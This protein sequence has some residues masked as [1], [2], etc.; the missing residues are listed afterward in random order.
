MKKIIFTLSMAIAFLSCKKEAPKDYIIL[1]GNILNLS[2]K[3]INLRGLNDTFSKTLQLAENGSFMDTLK[4]KL[5]HYMIY[6][7]KNIIYTYLEPGNEISLTYDAQNFKNTLKFTGAGS[8]IN[9]YLKAKAD[10]EREIIGMGNNVYKLNETDFTAKQKEI[11]AALLELVSQTDNLPGV[12]KEKEKRNIHYSYLRNFAAYEGNHQYYMEKPDFKISEGFLKELEELNYNQ[13]EDF[14]FSVD[15]GSLVSR[16]CKEEAKKLSIK[17]AIGEDVALL[18]AINTLDNENI[19]NTLLYRNAQYGIT[20][21]S[22]LEDYYQAF[23]NGSTLAEN[24]KEITESYNKLIKVAKGQPSPKFIDYEN[25]MGGTTSLDDL[26]GKYVY[27]DVW[28]TWCGPCKA[29]IPYLKKIEKAYH[30]KNIEFVSISLDKIADHDKWKQMILDEELGGIQ[31]LADNNFESAFAKDYYIKGI[32]KF[33]LL[34]P[35]G[36]IVDAN[37][38]RPSNEALIEL[39]E[40]LKL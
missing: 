2:G 19:K 30:G 28:A 18:K 38:P 20:Y 27:I 13:E 16:H 14:E 22:D 26:K 29:E 40:D 7:G 31:L 12:F 25:N 37:A 34:D 15:Y 33:I 3:D 10:K 24:K 17:D 4:L 32:P 21:T 8:E 1:S 11:Q 35:N 23:M 39:F 9:T 5:G 36:F 6:D